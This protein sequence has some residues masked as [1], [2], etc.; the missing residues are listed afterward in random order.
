MTRVM[1]YGAVAKVRTNFQNQALCP[2][3]ILTIPV[4]GRRMRQLGSVLYRCSRNL[5]LF[6]SEFSYSMSYIEFI[7]STANHC[8]TVSMDADDSVDRIHMKVTAKLGRDE[9]LELEDG[10]PMKGVEWNFGAARKTETQEHLGYICYFSPTKDPY[11]SLSQPEK[12]FAEIEVADREFDSLLTSL[13]TTIAAPTILISIDG[14]EFGIDPEGRDLIW[15][16]KTNPRL[17]IT[18]VGFT[19]PIAKYPPLDEAEGEGND[20]DTPDV[21]DTSKVPVSVSDLR[22]ATVT[23]KE[24]LRF[25]AWMIGGLAIAI[26]IFSCQR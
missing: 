11:G 6:G 5:S 20:M 24:S 22:Q 9:T 18:S 21:P 3:A 19:W 13:R 14:L 1:E 4:V 7:P 16:N 2:S 26:A 23:V 17:P 12:F 25:I 10:T 15:K 8:F